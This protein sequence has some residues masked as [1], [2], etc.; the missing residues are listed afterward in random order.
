MDAEKAFG[1]IAD[2]LDL[3]SGDMSPGEEAMIEAIVGNYI[4]NNKGSC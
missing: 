1:R 4:N 3:D 2:R